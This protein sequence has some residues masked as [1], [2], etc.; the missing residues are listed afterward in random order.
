VTIAA[1]VALGGNLE[2]A[3]RSSSESAAIGVDPMVSG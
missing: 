2:R 3:A 1:V